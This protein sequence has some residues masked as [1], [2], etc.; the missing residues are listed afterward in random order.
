MLSAIIHHPPSVGKGDMR[1]EQKTENAYMGHIK[2]APL[3]CSTVQHMDP[4]IL[5]KA[6][7]VQPNSIAQ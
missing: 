5:Y 4:P 2:A 7:P 1:L 6:V 3:Y